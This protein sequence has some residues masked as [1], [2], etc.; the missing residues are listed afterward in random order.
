[1]IEDVLHLMVNVMVTFK[2]LNVDQFG[3]NLISMGYDGNNVFQGA[4]TNVIP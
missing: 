4:K 2:G 3:A 1:M